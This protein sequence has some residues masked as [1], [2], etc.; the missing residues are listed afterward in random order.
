M[1]E[2]RQICSDEWERLRDI[3]LEALADTPSAFSTT[4]A[5]AE[6]FPDSVWQERA[7]AGAAGRDQITVVAVFGERT[8][9]MTVAL[10][11]P[12]LDLSVVPVVSV[13]V[14]PSE[15]RQGVAV[16]LLDIAEEWA[17]GH[18]ASRTSLWVEEENAPARSVYASTGYIST[19][20]RQ[21]MPAS[22]GTWEIRL[23]K[24]LKTAG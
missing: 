23:E 7:I 17:R 4:L 10:G 3:R 14:A 24:D 12:G 18:G 6:A 16:R 9:G 15:R 2:V 20:D 21:Q 1:I 5:Q 22:P 19:P 8:V 11:R 13:F